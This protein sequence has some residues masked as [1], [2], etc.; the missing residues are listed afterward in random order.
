MAALSGMQPFESPN[1]FNQSVTGNE[2]RDPSQWGTPNDP[3][4]GVLGAGDTH[5]PA[6]GFTM[7]PGDEFAF[8]DV[9]Q[10]L[11]EGYHGHVLDVTP[12]N[13][14]GIGVSVA[15]GGANANWIHPHN[16]QGQVIEQELIQAHQMDMGGP[17]REMWVNPPDQG[18][19]S[20]TAWEMRATNRGAQV[21]GPYNDS[22]LLVSSPGSMRP[23]LDN[24]THNRAKMLR[25]PIVD[26][27]E[28][29]WL[30][31][32]AAVTAQ[33]E[34]ARSI[35]SPSNSYPDYIVQDPGEGT[36]YAAPADPQ[37]GAPATS[38]EVLIGLE[39]M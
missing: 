33:S 21:G 23:A 34:D 5:T 25:V 9:T 18:S 8:G 20:V 10:Y 6:D 29:P 7:A 35:L 2:G 22:G 24:S 31:N 14:D 36:A 11:D 19:E 27:G 37:M 13:P 32:I 26:Y 15:H 3:S 1:V 39:W 12:I 28:R 38:N 4:H 17:L 30:N 16:E